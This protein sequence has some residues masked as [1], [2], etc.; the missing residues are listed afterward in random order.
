MI[1]NFPRQRFDP[2]TGRIICDACWNGKH[3]RKEFFAHYPDRSQCD[4]LCR[5][6]KQAEFV[7]KEKDKVKKKH[8]PS[9]ASTLNNKVDKKQ[10]G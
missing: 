8:L 6:Q 4:C 1:H 7:A 2:L 9:P 5:E 10:V 3:C